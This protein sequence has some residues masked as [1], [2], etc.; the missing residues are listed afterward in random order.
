MTIQTMHVAANQD[1][2]ELFHFASDNESVLGKLEALQALLYDLTEDTN[3]TYFAL[4]HQVE[5][6]KGEL[7][8]ARI[9]AAA[10]AQR[11][12]VAS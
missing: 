1:R 7:V 3:L 6:I 10:S 12:K 2:N 8:T 9:Y 5:F 4:L 11:D